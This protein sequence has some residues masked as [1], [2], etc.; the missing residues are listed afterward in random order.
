MGATSG[1]LWARRRQGSDVAF[2]KT[3]RILGMR[4]ISSQYMTYALYWRQMNYSH[5]AL[6]R[7]LVN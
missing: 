3:A 2:S 6:R 5:Q 7:S 4:L 1:V